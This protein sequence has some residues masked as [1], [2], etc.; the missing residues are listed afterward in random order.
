MLTVADLFLSENERE[1][2]IFHS[3]YFTVDGG[4]NIVV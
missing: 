1:L 2:M 4:Q 3:G